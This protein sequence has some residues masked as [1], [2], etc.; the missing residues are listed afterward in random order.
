MVRR[1]YLDNSA[2]TR[3][4]DRVLEAMMPYF[5]EVYGNPS[6][7]HQFGQQAKAAVDKARHEVA[8]LINA[9]PNEIVFTS[10]GTEANNL[11]IRGLAESAAKALRRE[12]VDHGNT[13]FVE[14]KELSGIHIIISNIEHSAVYRV[15]NY[16]VSHGA[17]LSVIQADNDGIVSPEDVEAAID[18]SPTII[19]IMSANNEIGT[20]QPIRQIAEKVKKF[21]ALGHKIWLHTD[22]VQAVGKMPVDVEELGCDL[23]SLSGHK[24]YAP[25]GIGALYIR[26]GV[27]PQPQMIG[28]HQ[29]RDRRGGT[30][31]VPNIV[32]LGAACT[33][34]AAEMDSELRRV[35]MLR[36]RLESAILEKIPKVYR[37]G[38]ADLRLPNISN[39]SFEG[40][41]GEALLINL[42]MHGIAVST[43]SACSSGTIE[44]SPVIKA[45]GRSDGLARGAIRF[46]LGRFNTESDIDYTVNRLEEAVISLRQLALASNGN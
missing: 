4:D 30:E 19:S 1:I 32:A 29:E 45:L 11:A 24:I 10:G 26:R 12:A 39:I 28:G 6:S 41:E 2:T 38:A 14:N 8:A 36:D 27:K 33:I 44:P 7:V 23:L 40:I 35:R 37:N 20:I 5:S 43:G 31:S 17:R 9:R 3:V 16:L 21:R 46:S 25:K 42:D 15:S 22:A 34:A 13:A 18:E